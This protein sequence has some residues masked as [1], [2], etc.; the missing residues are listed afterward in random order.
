MDVETLTD[1]SAFRG[2]RGE[3]LRLLTQLPFQSVFLTPQWQETWWR[4]FARERQ[5]YLLTVRSNDGVLRG[6]APLM[7]S[8]GGDVPARL[9]FIGDVE[10]CDYFDVLIDPAYEQ[11]V[12]E[13]LASALVSQANDEVALYLTNLSSHSRTPALLHQSLEDN[14]LAVVLAEIETCPTIVLPDTW[15]AYLETLRGKD[16]H[17]MRRKIR[18]AETTAH[19]GYTTA[20]DAATLDEALETFF[21]L[22]R[23]SQQPDKRHFMTADKAAFLRDL[24]HQ[25]WASGWVDLTTLQADGVPI[26]ALCCFPYERTYAAYNACYHPDYRHLSAGIVLFANRIQNA[27]AHGFTCFDFLRGNEP[28]KYRFGASDRP[29]LQLLARTACP[30]SGSCP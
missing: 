9:E 4:H 27:I 5:L 12:S 25:L 7:L 16:R 21:T 20:S 13:T 8:Q 14:G 24:T 26:A 22:H 15:E 23:M 6:L 1:A 18:R 28:Y 19:L 3:W 30:V 29:L 11:Q 10:L 17:E 2:L